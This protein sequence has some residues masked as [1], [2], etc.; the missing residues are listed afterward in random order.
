[1]MVS[2]CQKYYILQNRKGLIDYGCFS[3]TRNPNYLGEMMLYG[4]FALL[5]PNVYAWWILVFVWSTVFMLN[6]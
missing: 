2:D 5:C 4:S 1:M 6:M 3:C